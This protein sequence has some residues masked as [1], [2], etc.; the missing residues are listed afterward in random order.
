MTKTSRDKA[1]EKVFVEMRN[2]LL[3]EMEATGSLLDSLPGGVAYTN[4]D[5]VFQLVNPVFAELFGRTTDELLG[6]NVLEALKDTES[7][8]G[9]LVLKVLADG[10]PATVSGVA[11]T[12]MDGQGTRQETWNFSFNPV[13]DPAG[14]TIGVFGFAHRADLDAQ[15]QRE[16]ARRAGELV[17][18]KEFIERLINQVPAAIAYLDRSLVIRWSNSEF[19]RLYHVS[20]KRVLDHPLFDIFKGGE[21]QMGPLIRSVFDTGEPYRARS[22]PFIYHRGGKEHR[23]FWDITFYPV[24]GS[25]QQVNG[26]LMLSIE[27][28]EHVGKEMALADQLNTLQATDRMKSDF[29][30][31]ASHELRTPLTSILGYAE[32]LED[33][34]GGQLTPEQREFVAQIQEG[35]KRL[36]RLVE[37]LLDFAR[38]QAGT[39]KLFCED[40]DLARLI[41]REVSSLEPQ[42]REKA[43]ALSVDLPAEP[44]PAHID[45]RR[46]GQV[47]L[48]LVGNAIKYSAAGAHVTVTARQDDGHLLVEVS[49]TG[50]GINK[51]NLPKLFQRFYQVDADSAHT[52]GGAGLGLSISK[53]LVEA[54]GGTIGVM[55]EP[56]QGSRF[57]FTLPQAAVSNVVDIKRP[58][59]HK[60]S[61]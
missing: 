57:W 13:P 32:F 44:L 29:L 11:R 4:R 49:D 45:A 22:F 21:A 28:S 39:F 12:V 43:M 30:N 38:L 50:P 54:H 34:L 41:R 48:N 46:V 7:Q 9:A 14:K 56:G 5:L 2:L 47:I 40:T 26:V 55:S 42:A 51:E 24:T 3:K 1:K 61:G 58:R 37:D 16:A 36:Q 59:L 10:K 19:G 15:R 35:T 52:V 23:S 33:E 27:V 17:Q 6:E 8:V 60:R 53:A 20:G 18:Q 31:T 25:D